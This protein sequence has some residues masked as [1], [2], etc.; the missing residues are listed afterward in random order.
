MVNCSALCLVLWRPIDSHY[1]SLQ[2]AFFKERGA[3][4]AFEW[5]GS[6][7]VLRPVLRRTLRKLSRDRGREITF[8]VPGCGNSELSVKLQRDGFQDVTS[9]DFNATV[10]EGMGKSCVFTQ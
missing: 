3:N 8:L 1:Q 5:Y 6:Y 2:D 7:S 9:I 4:E 10:I